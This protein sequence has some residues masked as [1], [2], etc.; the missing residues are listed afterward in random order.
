M[1]NEWKWTV[2][3]MEDTAGNKRLTYSCRMNQTSHRSVKKERLDWWGK[4]CFHILSPS[5]QSCA[6]EKYILP[7]NAASKHFEV[8]LGISIF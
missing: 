7:C 2:S 6:E 4:G 5:D 1:D 3:E 8:S